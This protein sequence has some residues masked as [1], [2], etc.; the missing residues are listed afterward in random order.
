LRIAWAL[1]CRWVRAGGTPGLLNLLD[2][3]LDTVVV[4]RLGS[5]VEL[6]VAIRLRGSADDFANAHTVRIALSVALV[7]IAALDLPVLPIV[8]ARH[9]FPGYD[10]SN[11][12]G[13]RIAFEP[14][15]EGGY[16]L[17]FALDGKLD[18]RHNTTISVLLP[19]SN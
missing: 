7:E 5:E 18:T 4:D 6:D 16:D 14:S 10:L 15:S 9:R 17:S 2:C 1:P 13:A 3:Q 8:P 12:V 11:H 19:D